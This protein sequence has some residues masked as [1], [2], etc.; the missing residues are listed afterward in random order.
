MSDK[1]KA[2]KTAAK[3]AVPES[4]LLRRANT[5]KVRAASAKAVAAAKLAR[6]NSRVLAFKRAEKYAKEYRTKD[7]ALVHLRRVAR[8]SGQFFLEPEPKV[9]FVIRIRGLAGV[10]PRVRKVMQLLRLRQAHNGVFIKLS[11][12]TWQ[13]LRIVEPYIAYGYPSLSSVRQLIYKRGY[14]K[15]KNQ[16]IPI[17]DNAVIEQQLGKRGLICVEDLVH[18]IFTVGPNFKYASRFLWPFKLNSPTGGF[19]DIGRQFTD[20]GDCGNREQY[21]NKLIRQMN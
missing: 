2:K 15:I 6:K 16:R 8:Q 14:A 18:E 21:I 4:I 10:S 20:N 9:A 13:M 17:T 7:K 3:P 11:Y 5:A 19:K 12:A 1:S